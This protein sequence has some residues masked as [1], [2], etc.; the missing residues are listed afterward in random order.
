MEL[1]HTPH[2]VYAQSP[3]GACIAE[4]TFPAVR[5]GVW[6]IDHTFV[7]TSLRGQGA[8]DRL[9]RAVIA[10]AQEAGVRLTA[11]C[12]Y[13]SAWFARHPEYQSLYMPQEN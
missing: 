5:P 10:Q 13:A 1:I 9:V 2:R 4:I 11:T 3:N 6:N 12:S 7:D 8:A